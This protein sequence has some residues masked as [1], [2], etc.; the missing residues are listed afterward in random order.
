MTVKELLNAGFTQS[1]DPQFKFEFKI[2]FE[3]DEVSEEMETTPVLLWDNV[4]ARFCL[5]E[6]NTFIYL[7]TQDPKKA[8]EW[9]NA[10]SHF[11]PN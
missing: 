8:I 7:N 9:V 11:E 6:G 10:I 4:N 1:E 5:Y 3:N 2:E